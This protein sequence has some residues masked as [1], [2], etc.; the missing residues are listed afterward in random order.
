LHSRR[1][2]YIS[3]ENR[4]MGLTFVKA[5]HPNDL[6]LNRTAAVEKKNQGII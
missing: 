4:K 6:G 3:R 1:E 5:E 2:K